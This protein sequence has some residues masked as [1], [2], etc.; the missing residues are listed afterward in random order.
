MGLINKIREK[1]G[2]A[3]GII[4]I[5]LGLFVVGGDILSPNSTLLGGDQTIV[6]EI[7]GREISYQK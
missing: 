2:I 3:V 4:A 7:A 5:G 6:G 1:S